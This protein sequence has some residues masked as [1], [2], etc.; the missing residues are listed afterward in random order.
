MAGAGDIDFK[1]EK[2]AGE[3]YHNWKFQ[4]KMYLI[5]ER[6]LC[7]GLLLKESRSKEAASAE[8]ANKVENVS[9]KSPE[10]ALTTG[11]TSM[12]GDKWW[13]DSGAS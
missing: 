3:N 11:G 10:V 5:E 6:S 9:R 13:I 12:K 2:L 4:M 1:I 8:F 7:E